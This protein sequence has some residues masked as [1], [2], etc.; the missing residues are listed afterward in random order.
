MSKRN[1]PKRPSVVLRAATLP[2][3]VGLA[4]TLG[5]MAFEGHNNPSAHKADRLMN[6]SVAT[7]PIWNTPFQVASLSDDWMLHI[8]PAQVNGKAVLLAQNT[9]STTTTT[10]ISTGNESV[11]PLAVKNDMT[12]QLEKLALEAQ[13]TKGYADLARQDYKAAKEIFGEAVK[14]YPQRADL[15]R[16]LGY[17]EANLGDKDQAV[18]DFS[19]S[20]EIEPKDEQTQKVLDQMKKEAKL[21]KGYAAL[22][23]KDYKSA[24]DVFKEAVDKDP[25]NPDL[26]RQLAYIELGLGNKDEALKDFEKVNELEP[27]DPQIEAEIDQIKNAPLLEE[28]YKKLASKDYEAALKL[29]QGVV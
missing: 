3:S 22:C 21:D 4:A 23:Q 27:G 29:F 10:T 24:Q 12:T 13:L 8:V 14:K 25:N 18:N 15:W 2:L 6:T 9:T 11:A 17:I 19:K 26:W 5:L 7:A 16:Q 20:L 1:R 28:G